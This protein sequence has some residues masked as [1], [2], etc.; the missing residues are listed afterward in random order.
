M[1]DD[2]QYNKASSD[3]FIYT[4]FENKKYTEYLHDVNYHISHTKIFPYIDKLKSISIIHSRM[5]FLY[6]LIVIYHICIFFT[7]SGTNPWHV[8]RLFY[9]TLL[10]TVLS[11]MM[12]VNHNESIKK[13]KLNEC[14]IKTENIIE[15]E[16]TY[17]Y[18]E[19]KKVD[20]SLILIFHTESNIIVAVLI[21]LLI[22][23][24]VYVFLCQKIIPMHIL[25][26]AL[27]DTF[28]DKFEF[29]V[30]FHS[31]PLFIIQ[32]FHS[33]F[34]YKMYKISVEI[35]LYE[36]YYVQYLINK[37]SLKHDCKYVYYAIF[38]QF[39]NI[40]FRSMDTVCGVCQSDFELSDDILTLRC[41][42]VLH[43]NCYKQ[44]RSNNL[45][46]CPYCLYPMR[47]D[48]I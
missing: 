44:M 18:D 15:R 29:S 48:T 32:M 20:S 5:M 45:K 31:C 9:I 26:Y 2:I 11:I 10:A 47:N 24:V 28:T 22:Q 27:F 13:N 21:L 7:Y 19:V 1:D 33:Y 34:I 16:Y 41:S 17:R 38:K 30:I 12:C 3:K 8:L 42:H 43:T 40:E 25:F 14:P 36:E 46:N 6:G 23:L 37:Y 4:L 39:N 35:D